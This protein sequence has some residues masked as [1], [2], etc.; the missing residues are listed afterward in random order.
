MKNENSILLQDEA[1]NIGDVS[2][3]L[4]E[5][6]NS[7]LMKNISLMNSLIDQIGRDNTTATRGAVKIRLT[8]MIVRLLKGN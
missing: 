2:I 6:E 5:D 4:P 1:L 7:D 3:E 8:A